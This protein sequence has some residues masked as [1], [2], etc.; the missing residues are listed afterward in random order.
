MLN[1]CQSNPYRNKLLWNFNCNSN[2]FIEEN[3]FQIAVCKMA[4]ILFRLQCFKRML[5]V[6]SHQRYRSIL[7]IHLH[8]V[9]QVTD[10]DTMFS[11]ELKDMERLTDGQTYG[12]ADR[13]IQGTEIPLIPSDAKQKNYPV[14]ILVL[15]WKREYFNIKSVFSGIGIP[16]I[17]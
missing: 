17:K 1:H 5:H 9:W 14:D 2:F 8:L 10:L 11:R 15:L 13:Q 6:D 12:R 3:T 16:N 7:S 4:A